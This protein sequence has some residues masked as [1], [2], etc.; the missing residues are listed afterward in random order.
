MAAVHPGSSSQG[1]IQTMPQTPAPKRGRSTPPPPPW[2]LYS[3]AA[4]PQRRAA[5][6]SASSQ[7]IQ[8]A[9]AAKATAAAPAEVPTAS[10]QTSPRHPA[11][12][13]LLAVD[14]LEAPHGKFL[15]RMLRTYES[16]IELRQVDESYRAVDPMTIRREIY[17]AVANGGLSGAEASP[18][19]HCTGALQPCLDLFAFRGYQYPDGQ[20]VRIDATMIENPAT[21]LSLYAQSEWLLAFL[22][23]DLDEPEDMRMAATDILQNGHMQMDVVLTATPPRD[24]VE[25]WCKS[26]LR[27]RPAKQWGGKGATA[28]VASM[29]SNQTK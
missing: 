8:P 27:W 19:L 22:H 17:M 25:W 12:N 11:K 1:Q 5:S 21:A 24:S 26:Q 13:V 3:A 14:D 2:P 20:L 28:Q 4:A 10:S 18:F 7:P 9:T 15:F 23:V 29:A 6:V 16:P